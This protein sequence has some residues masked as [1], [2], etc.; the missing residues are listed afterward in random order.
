MDNR[1]ANKSLNTTE[2]VYN[3]PHLY[4]C[5]S[6]IHWTRFVYN[7]FIALHTNTALFVMSL[8]RALGVVV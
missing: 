2:Q 8:R 6:E 5:S 3:I 4:R 7:V 1:L